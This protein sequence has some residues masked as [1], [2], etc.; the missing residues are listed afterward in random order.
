MQLTM[1]SER[2][3]PF[4][5]LKLTTDKI[6]KTGIVLLLS[7]II[8]MIA[9]SINEYQ[10]INDSAKRVAHTHELLFYSQKVLIL[11]VDIET[12]ARG[13]IITW[14]KPFLA[15]LKKSQKEIYNELSLVKTITGDNPEQQVRIDSLTMYNDKA[16]AF[17]RPA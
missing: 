11:L 6:L 17:I 10:K 3:Q 13:Y 5:K 14:K 12:G 16:V 1:L 9:N 15:S 7:A 4:M 2:N 8:G